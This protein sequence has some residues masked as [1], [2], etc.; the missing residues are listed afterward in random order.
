MRMPALSGEKENWYGCSEYMKVDH[1]VE[2]CAD[3]GSNPMKFIDT[4][5]LLLIPQAVYRTTLHINLLKSLY[6][7]TQRI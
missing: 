4:T 2:T 1:H 7:R 5:I 6:M 3:C